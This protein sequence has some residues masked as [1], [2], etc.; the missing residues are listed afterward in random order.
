MKLLFDLSSA[1]PQGNMQINGGGEYSYL[2]FTSVYEAINQEKDEI[3]VILNQSRGVNERVLSF[4]EKHSVSVWYFGSVKQFQDRIVSG[5]YDTVVLPVCYA[6]YAELKVPEKVRVI[7]IIHDLCD[8]YYG[9][10]NVKYGRYVNLSIKNLV[11]K[12][13]YQVCSPIWTK[14]RIGLYNQ[15][16][17]LNK[18]QT[19]IT[20]T[21][22]SKS[23]M[24]RYLDVSHLDRIHVFYTPDRHFDDHDFGTEEEI[25]HQ[26]RLKKKQY[27]ML[28]SGCRWAKNN[29]I[30]LFV[31][32]KMFSL[33]KYAEMLQDFKV[34]LLG[35][36]KA[37]LKYY[38]R[39]LKN[40]DRFVFESYV[41]DETLNTLYKNAYLFVFPSVLEGFGLPPLEA[42]KYET[43]VA[44]SNAMSIPEVCGNGAIYFD[45]QSE[46]AIEMAIIRSFDREYMDLKKEQGRRRW[47]EIS[48]KRKEDLEG[49]IALILKEK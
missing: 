32:D 45:P 14:Y 39:K 41:N 35:V 17:R 8:I 1:Q 28:S 48:Q 6:F 22:Y 15:V 16:I 49:L 31:L 25:L 29:A 20:V 10:L 44:C 4:C 3:H 12:I 11:K 27:F 36:D 5:R 2:L 47:L 46:D 7:S 13:V 33:Q 23:T 19:L 42:M 38:R 30:V 43:A 24:Q 21:N 37:Y 40:K 9:M 34:V 18:N 26:Y